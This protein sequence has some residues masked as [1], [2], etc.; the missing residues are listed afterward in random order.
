M[1]ETATI[2]KRINLL[3]ALLGLVMIIELWP[4]HKQSD[5]ALSTAI[6]KQLV[7]QQ[8]GLEEERAGLKSVI[9][10]QRTEMERLAA[11]DSALL[12]GLKKNE[13]RLKELK[14]KS[15]ETTKHINSYGSDDIRRAFAELKD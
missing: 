5:S 1:I 14:N 13:T 3:Y 2:L 11:R 9:A 7:E 10:S 15:D 8:K 12:Q 6:T 4:S